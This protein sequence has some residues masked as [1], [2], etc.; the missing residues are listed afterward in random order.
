MSFHVGQKVVCVD[1]NFKSRGALYLDGDG[2]L[3]RSSGN[4]GGLRVGEVY[5][6]AKIRVGEME[7]TLFLVEVG[8]RGPKDTGY[9]FSRFRPIQERKTD[10]S[11]A[12]EIL[13]KVSRNG[14]VRA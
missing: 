4:T 10:I 6:V 8:A 2:D 12:H 13:R 3:K 11:F 1:A 7:N 9:R 14:R 5:T